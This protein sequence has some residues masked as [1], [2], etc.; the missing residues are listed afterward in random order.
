MWHTKEGLREKA[1]AYCPEGARDQEGVQMR[2]LIYNIRGFGAP[3]RRSQLRDYIKQHRVDIIGLQ[4]TIK[5]EFS[6]L[7]LRRLE[8][9]GQFAWNWLP[10]SGHSGGML[11]GFWDDKFEVG[12]WRKGDFFISATILQRNNNLK[13]CFVLV[14]GPADHSRTTEFL[15]ELVD[16][17]EGSSLP[18]VVVGDFNL[19]RLARDKSN[20]CINWPRVRR[21]NDAIAAMSLRE[22]SQAGARFTWTNN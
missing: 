5:Q 8:L 16:E 11:L 18:I 1:G 13:W 3:G 14:C 7:E 21:F 15:G 6:T 2:F 12:E 9:G 4:E 19:I 10:A 17:V 20:A 22:I